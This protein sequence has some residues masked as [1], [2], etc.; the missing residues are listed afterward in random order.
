MILAE[1]KKAHFDY[2]ILQSWEAGLVLAG[3]EVKAVRA[4]QISLKE[5][6][7]VINLNPKTKRPEARLLNCHINKYQKA[8]PL[9]GYDPTR[10]RRLLLHQKEIN[11]IYGKIQPKGL[12]LLPLRV[13]TKGTKIKVAIGLGRGKKQFDK[14][15]A[16]KKREVDRTLKRKLKNQ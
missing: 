16:T 12:T 5:S 2:Q 1:N 13:Y 14:R 10:S 11:S 4:G 15:A 9:P 7:V 3:Y 6:F 8:G